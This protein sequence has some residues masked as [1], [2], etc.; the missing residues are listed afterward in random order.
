MWSVQT[1]ASQQDQHEGPPENSHWREAIFCPHCPTCP[2]CPQR[3]ARRTLMNSHIRLKHEGWQWVLSGPF[4]GS[5]LSVILRILSTDISLL[6]CSKHGHTASLYV[7][8]F[9]WWSLPLQWVHGDAI[10]IS[11]TTW[12]NYETITCRWDREDNSFSWNHSASERSAL[13]RVWVPA[14]PVGSQTVVSLSH[15]LSR[16]AGVGGER[17]L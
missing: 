5:N 2:H 1:W 14:I 6:H 10:L 11:A 9:T 8:S 13:C 17:M 4:V 15:Q 12:L 16:T 3:A 7:N